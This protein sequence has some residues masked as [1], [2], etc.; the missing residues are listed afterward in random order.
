MRW[1]VCWKEENKK[2]VNWALWNSLER[3]K[4]NDLLSIR[5]E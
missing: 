3:E 2:R 5:I 4:K 1:I